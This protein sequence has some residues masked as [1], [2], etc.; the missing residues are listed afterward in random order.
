[1]D[2]FPGTGQ[3]PSWQKARRDENWNDFG[4]SG[5]HRWPPADHGVDADLR[6]DNWPL[7]QTSRRV[8]NRGEGKLNSYSSPRIRGS[9]SFS[10]S[11]P[12]SKNFVNRPDLSWNFVSFVQ[13]RR[14]AWNETQ[15]IISLPNS[16]HRFV[17]S[18]EFIDYRSWIR[19]FETTRSAIR[20]W[21]ARRIRYI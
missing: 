13:I 7:G 5:R 4:E 18:F 3:C 12:S 9:P 14:D 8:K 15:R 17:R 6:L 2:Y 21:V 16:I 1:M 20:V 11:N 19:I 10:S